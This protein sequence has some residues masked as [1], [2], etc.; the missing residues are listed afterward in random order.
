MESMV[1]YKSTP[2]WHKSR[3][4]KSKQEPTSN[5]CPKAFDHTL[6]DRNKTFEIKSN[7]IS[8]QEH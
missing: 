6:T 4:K 3:L 8:N 2:T 1:K 5:Q 7:Q